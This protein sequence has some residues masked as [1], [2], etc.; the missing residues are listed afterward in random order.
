M[1]ASVARASS[2][3]SDR[4]IDFTISPLSGA[5]VVRTRS[6]FVHTVTEVMFS[7]IDLVE[8]GDG[9]AARVTRG[10]HT[11]RCASLLDRMF[12]VLLPNRLFI[13]GGSEVV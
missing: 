9:N 8:L 7:Y 2:S 12:L 11:L 1:R 3:F 4:L 10:L 5:S 6:G 13:G